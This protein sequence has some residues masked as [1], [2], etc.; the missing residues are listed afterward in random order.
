MLSKLID[1][2]L[3]KQRKASLKKKRFQKQKLYNL[4][5]NNGDGLFAHQFYGSKS[6][7]QNKFASQ[8]LTREG[9]ETK[10]ILQNKI[11]V[12]IFK[13]IKT[14]KDF[15]KTI[16][17]NKKKK[18]KKKQGIPK[19]KKKKTRRDPRYMDFS[20]ISK[21]KKTED[22]KPVLKFDQPLFLKGKEREYKLLHEELSHKKVTNSFLLKESTTTP[23]YPCWNESL[24]RVVISNKLLSQKFVNRLLY[25][26]KIKG[27]ERVV[28]F[29][30]KK[31]NKKKREPTYFRGKRIAE[32]ENKRDKDWLKN[33]SALLKIFK[34]KKNTLI[35]QK[36]FFTQKKEKRRGNKVIN[37]TKE[38]LKA[39]N[40]N[41][42]KYLS[43]ALAIAAFFTFGNA[44]ST[45]EI[46]STEHIGQIGESGE[47]IKDKIEQ[48][49]ERERRRIEEENERERRRIEEER[50]KIEEEIQ[51]IMEEKIEEERI[52][53]EITKK[54]NEYYLREKK[55]NDKFLKTFK[56]NLKIF[57]EE[58]FE[59]YY[60]SVDNDGNET[61]VPMTNEIRNLILS[62]IK[63]TRSDIAA[64]ASI[65]EDIALNI[66][67]NDNCLPWPTRQ[68]W[69]IKTV[70]VD[71]SKEEPI[72]L[73][74]VKRKKDK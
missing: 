59:K 3:W 34:K 49:N 16:R 30:E 53:K 21:A 27:V 17:K 26:S 22:Q 47:K 2:P 60:V 63:Q 45:G 15:F 13:K 12:S 43:N 10:S 31:G 7:N 39:L 4:S 41:K 64:A 44:L 1:K 18:E 6:Q 52:K 28:F 61:E 50:R 70:D 40:K 37:K 33:Q 38:K 57:K 19:E 72:T 58:L 9:E 65:T 74:I 68:E 29:K 71:N 55:E 23:F 66:G 8:F 62:D 25:L 46:Q 42:D 24:G 11:K 14:R 35:K 48:E 32:E 54:C 73:E 20:R 69:D 56:K 51:R 5:K 67:T 36:I